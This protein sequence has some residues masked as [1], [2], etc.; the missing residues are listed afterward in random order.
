MLNLHDSMQYMLNIF[1]L[2][3]DSKN[4]KITNFS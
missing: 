2:C 4:A 1:Q 3:L